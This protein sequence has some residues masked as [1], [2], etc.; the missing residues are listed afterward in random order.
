[1]IPARLFDYHILFIP[2]LPWSLSCQR[3][4]TPSLRTSWTAT[5]PRESAKRKRR[6]RGTAS[7][8]RALTKRWRPQRS[9]CSPPK[10]SYCQRRYWK[11]DLYQK[12]TWVLFSLSLSSFPFVIVCYL[13]SVPL[14]SWAILYSPALLFFALLYSILRRYND[15]LL[16]VF[17][18]HKEERRGYVKC[19]KVR[20]FNVCTTAGMYCHKEHNIVWTGSIIMLPLLC[21]CS[22]PF[23]KTFSTVFML[24]PVV[25]CL[26]GIRKGDPWPFFLGNHLATNVFVIL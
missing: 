17:M 26:W 14:L 6:R 11:N 19:R 5:S 10:L 8:R 23:G 25:S 22:A 24:I 7:T 4:C 16:W 1:M 18:V 13:T 12:F 9:L 21:V 3:S 20:E 15:N 2:V